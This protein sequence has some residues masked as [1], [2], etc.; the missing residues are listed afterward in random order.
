M[1]AVERSLG[2][3][4]GTVH[5]RDPDRYAALRAC[6]AARRAAE[7]GSL[8]DRAKQALD[9]AIAGPRFRSAYEVARSLGVYSGT[10]ERWFPERYAELVALHAERRQQASRAVLHQRCDALCAAVF[11]LV[12]SGQHPS[13]PTALAHAGL[14]PTLCRVPSVRPAFEAALS[15]CGL[16]PLPHSLGSVPLG[17]GSEESDGE[18]HLDGSRGLEL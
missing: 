17:R 18:G 9:R 11:D 7:R 1:A 8:R 2:L 12:R 4:R 16:A 5:R 13:F 14:P 15:A 6:C 3:S 10:L